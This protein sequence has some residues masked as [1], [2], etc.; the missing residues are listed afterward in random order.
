MLVRG[1]RPPT[2]AKT[3]NLPAGATTDVR[4]VFLAAWRLGLK[5]VTV[6]RCGSRPDQT[7]TY[8]AHAEAGPSVRVSSTYAG[9]CAGRECEF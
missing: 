9:G 6:Y 4:R 2:I 3:V 1:K 5:G 7:L 8:L